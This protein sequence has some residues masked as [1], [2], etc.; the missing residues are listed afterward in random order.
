MA[1]VAELE[2]GL[3]SERT[4]AAADEVRDAQIAMMIVSER[5]RIEISRIRL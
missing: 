3:I 1:S 5:T 2:A 4:K